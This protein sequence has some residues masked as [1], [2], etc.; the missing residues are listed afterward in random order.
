MSGWCS[1]CQWTEY[2]FHCIFTCHLYKNNRDILQST[3]EIILKREGLDSVGDICMKTLNG[4][5]DNINKQAQ[6]EILSVLHQYVKGTE[7][8]S[9]KLSLRHCVCVQQMLR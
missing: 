9:H 5:I 3:V 1:A 4:G 2:T 8:F 6:N 7:R